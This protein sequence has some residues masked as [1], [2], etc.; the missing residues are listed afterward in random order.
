MQKNNKTVLHLAEL[1]LFFFLAGSLGIL[2]S[3]FIH[4]PKHI[5]S[6]AWPFL[7][8]LTVLM[9]FIVGLRFATIA[10]ET[11]IA[12]LLRRSMLNLIPQDPDDLK[13]LHIKTPVDFCYFMM[14]I[15]SFQPNVE[16]SETSAFFMD[17]KRVF[18][19]QQNSFRKMFGR[20]PLKHETYNWF[21]CL[22]AEL[23]E[24]TGVPTSTMAG[25]DLIALALQETNPELIKLINE[26]RSLRLE[27]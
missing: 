9:I 13:D 23:S 21:S 2:L 18:V 7:L 8:G 12:I 20:L 3:R 19:A 6:E 10:V 16:F 22:A 24:K 17:T 14:F 5:S 15:S 1:A 25:N 11:V 27:I 26:N 4:C